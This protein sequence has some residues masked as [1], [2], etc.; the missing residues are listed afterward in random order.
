MEEV[1][2]WECDVILWWRRMEDQGKSGK[3]SKGE[4]LKGI[5]VDTYVP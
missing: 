4:G 1:L 2:G 3:K 5:K